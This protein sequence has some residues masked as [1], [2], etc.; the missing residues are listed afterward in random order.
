MIPTKT[1]T[2]FV[3][4]ALVL[5]AAAF[6]IEL[7]LRSPADIAQSDLRV[8]QP[9]G[10]AVAKRQMPYRDF[11]LEY[12]PGALPMFIGPG[13]YL[14]AR[15]STTGATWAP[16]NTDANRYYRA[17]TGLVIANTVVI[18]VLTAFS[19][20]ALS[21]P[22]RRTG[23]ALA[24]VA[25]SPLLLGDVFPGRFDVWPAALTALALTLGLFRRHC[26]AGGALGVG[27]ATK[28]YPVLLLPVLIAV[29]V[30]E[31]GIRAG[32]F[33]ATS[34]LAAVAAVFLPFL[35]V[36][37]SGTW[38]SLRVQFQGGLQIESVTASL[39]VN[40]EHLENKLG[41]LGFPPA[42][43]LTNRAIES[44]IQRSVLVGPGVGATAATASV[45]LGLVL[46][47]L[48][49]AVARSRG[50][51][52]ED[53][54]RFSAAVVACAL[55]FSSVLSPQY[56]I[57]L[58]PLV[59]LVAGRRGAAA[60]VLLAAAAILT[61]VW[62][63]SGYQRYENGLGDGPAALLFARNLLVVATALVLVWPRPKATSPFTA[64][65]RE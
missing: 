42:S 47:A 14:V 49:V 24:V 31:R 20:A 36:A 8:Y 55:V 51:P 12:P 40:A 52:R 57:W 11:A 41:S 25:L 35:I 60:T 54:V 6:V 26:L 2:A 19:L 17:F 53:L 33:A 45:L 63:P 61:N 38:H 46:I 18:V 65:T 3:A 50:D 64:H 28:V 58:I 10:S 13:T 37:P 59:P 39:L 32:V 56:L 1:L 29:A 43:G 34:A 30:R 44:G 22:A 48:W 4:G 16:M 7:A 27:A 5:L 23:F 62:F 9:Y 15:G 21:R